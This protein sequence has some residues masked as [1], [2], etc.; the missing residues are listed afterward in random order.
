M[1]FELILTESHLVILHM[2]FLQLFSICYEKV[3]YLPCERV[4][5]FP[6]PLFLLAGLIIKPT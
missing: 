1:V 6:Y 5:A 4:R 3:S 2:T